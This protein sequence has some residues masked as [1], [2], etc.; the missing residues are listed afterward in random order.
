MTR[1]YCILTRSVPR[2]HLL[3]ATK[4]SMIQGVPVKMSNV[5]RIDRAC[6]RDQGFPHA[7]FYFGLVFEIIAKEPQFWTICI[8][9]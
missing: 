2:A 9:Q 4:I 7:L 5:F 8:C 6:L 1:F 3:N